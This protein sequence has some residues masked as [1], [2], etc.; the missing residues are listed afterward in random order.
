M[1][2]KNKKDC[3]LINCAQNVKLEKGFISF[4]NCCKQI[5]TCS[6]QIPD[7][8]CI[9]KNVNDVGIDNESFSYTK[10]YQDHVPSSFAYK[11][12]CVD[13]KYSKDV[14]LY[15]VKYSVFKFIKS[16][17]KEYGYCKKE[18]KKHFNKN[19]VMSATET[20]RFEMTNICWICG[21]S[22]MIKSEIIVMLQLNTEKQHIGL[23]ILI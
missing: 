10:K 7:F 9:C 12:V 5:H 23:V 1:L 19:L 15:R 20:A 14:L 17:L 8:E 22:M 16:V 6:F 3:L 21:K 4:K 13:N 18:I 11:V 2:I